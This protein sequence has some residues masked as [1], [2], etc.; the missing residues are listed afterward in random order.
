MLVYPKE[1]NGFSS[2][3]CI[4]LISMHFLSLKS[5]AYLPLLNPPYQNTL[6]THFQRPR[7]WQAL[8]RS[9]CVVF[10]TTGDGQNHYSQVLFSILAIN[11]ISGRISSLSWGFPETRNPAAVS[12]PDRGRIHSSFYDRRKRTIQPARHRKCI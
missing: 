8:P 1:W 12:S 5:N 9:L 6:S 7:S 10:W 11:W 2:Q 4:I 3:Q